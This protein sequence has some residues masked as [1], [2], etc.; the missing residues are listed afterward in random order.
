MS[1]FMSSICPAVYQAH[2]SYISSTSSA[3]LK[4]SSALMLPSWTALGMPV[5]PKTLKNTVFS[6]FFTTFLKTSY[7]CCCWRFGPLLGCFLA[8]LELPFGLSWASWAACWAL[9][10]LSWTHLEPFW[11][12]VGAFLS[13]S[14]RLLCLSGPI[15]G[16]LWPP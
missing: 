6:L 15:L 10:G 3:L 16:H 14:W 1:S 11:S 4:P 5:A 12:H 8:S 9:L 13:L 2:L 7:S